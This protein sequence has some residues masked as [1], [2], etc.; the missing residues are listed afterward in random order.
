MVV[1][2]M[3]IWAAR[4][5]Y[6]SMVWRHSYPHV[7]HHRDDEFQTPKLEFSQEPKLQPE[8]CISYAWK[9]ASPEGQERE[10]IVDRLCAEAEG[11]GILIL[12]DTSVL[13]L[14]DRITK[15]MRRIGRADRVFV[16]LSDKYLKSPNCMFELFEVWRNCRQEEAEFQGRVRVYALECAKIF[17]PSDRARYAI[18]WKQQ[19]DALHAII[20]EH[21]ADILGEADFNKFKLMQ[22]FAHRVGDILALVADTLLPRSFEDLARYGLDDPPP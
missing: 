1:R 7:E 10:T 18:H 17:T 3:W 11:R 20:K 13:G 2:Q 22:D 14:G 15:F 21:G 8:Y 6:R 19:H 12:R 9:D 4:N 5:L 16:V